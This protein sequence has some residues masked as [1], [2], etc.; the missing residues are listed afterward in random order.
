MLLSSC[1]GLL[2]TMGTWQQNTIIWMKSTDEIFDEKYESE[3]K[4]TYK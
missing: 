2:Y 4:Y 3:L 1:T